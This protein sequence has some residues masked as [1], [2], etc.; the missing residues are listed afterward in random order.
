MPPFISQHGATTCSVIAY[1]NAHVWLHGCYPLQDATC[2]AYPERT[3]RFMKYRHRLGPSG[4]PVDEFPHHPIV[5]V[6]VPCRP[7][8]IAGMPAFFAAVCR[9]VGPREYVHHAAFIM[10]TD[11]GRADVCNITDPTIPVWNMSFRQMWD[12]LLAKT[13]TR[14]VVDPTDPDKTTFPQIWTVNETHR[15]HDGW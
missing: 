3:I 12:L 15:I 11:D 8:T 2:I 9:K 10:R 14:N 7:S 4:L 1:V 6:S 13:P 5:G